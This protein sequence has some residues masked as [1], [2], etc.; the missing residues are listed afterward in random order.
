MVFS[1]A[2]LAVA[3]ATVVAVEGFAARLGAQQ[4]QQP[5]LTAPSRRHLSRC[6]ATTMAAKKQTTMPLRQ[7]GSSDL[8]VSQVGI[9]AMMFGLE[10]DEAQSHRLLDIA[11]D[12]YGVNFIDNSEVST[13][14][15]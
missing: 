6:H 13:A 14:V 15:K 7:L 1:S 9:G 10:T 5:R 12:E 11:F 4:I 8:K 2:V 3:A